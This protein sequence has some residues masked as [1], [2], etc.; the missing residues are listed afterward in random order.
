MTYA[1]DIALTDDLI[2]GRRGACDSIDA[3]AVA[4]M[5]AQN[6]FRTGLDIARYT[7]GIMRADM[8]AYDADPAAYTQSLG[9]WHGFIA[10]QKMIA[11]KKHFGTTKGRYLY[12]LRDHIARWKEM[13]VNKKTLTEALK[14]PASE[15]EA[16]AHTV[17]EA[18]P[19][20]S[21]PEEPQSTAGN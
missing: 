8:A 14:E 12:L 20:E 17:E 18:A 13:P 5:R 10:Q 15:P 16:A 19:A 3:E 7:A 1:Q 9:C 6:K 2:R 11:V 4:R 21:A